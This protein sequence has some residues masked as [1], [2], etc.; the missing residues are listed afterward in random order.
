[1]KIK[2]K[3]P[4][5]PA[6]SL[7]LT[8]LGTLVLAFSTGALIIPHKLV[9]G[10]VSGIAIILD[11][12][13]PLGKE[14]WIAVLSIVLFI[15]G[16]VLLGKGFMLKTLVSTFLYPP[17]AALFSR[18]GIFAG[19][20]WLLTAAILSG[21]LTGLGCALAF[22]GGG[23]TGGVDILALVIENRTLKIRTS[24]VIFI[25]DSAVIILGVLIL[26]DTVLAAL[27]VLSASLTALVIDKIFYS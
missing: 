21:V 22:L 5:K 15:F 3:K 19:E 9:V 8:V 23:S 11:V 10:G 6:A 7:L 26:R 17:A 2:F 13:F 20:G 12:F 27:G 16:L 24:R 14:A 4:T 25:I 18:I 1:M